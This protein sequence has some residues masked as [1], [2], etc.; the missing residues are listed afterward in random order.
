VEVSLKYAVAER[1]RRFLISA[2]PAGMVE[3]RTI[4][5][6]YV[7]GTRLRLR[8]VTKDDGSVV[9]RLTQKIRR[10]RASG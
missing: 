8:E 10:V 4:V 6:H 7:T 3:T 9:R 2:L 1:E 5:D